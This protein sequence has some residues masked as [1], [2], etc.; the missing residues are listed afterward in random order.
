MQ[1]ILNLGIKLEVFWPQKNFISG[2]SWRLKILSFVKLLSCLSTAEIQ[3][4]GEI[5]TIY[6]LIFMQSIALKF[7]RSKKIFQFLMNF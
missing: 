5:T 3:M 6:Q 4:W 2:G 7:K 1:A